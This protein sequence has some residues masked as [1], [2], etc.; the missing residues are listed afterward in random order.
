M[1]Q[2][3]PLLD[4]EEIRFR[5]EAIFP[6]GIPNRQYAVRDIAAKTIFVM[7]YI[8]A[9]EGRDMWLRPDQVT[10]MTNRQSSRSDDESRIEWAKKSIRPS[11]EPIKGRWYAQNTREP[12][13]DETLRQ[14]LLLLGAVT[15]RKG[16][17]TT[18]PEGRY[19]LQA[20]FA[21][22]FDPS[23]TGQGL[24]TAVDQWKTLHL[25][26][27]ALARVALVRKATVETGQGVIVRFPNDETRRLAEGPSSVI[28][29]AVVE[30]FAPR[31]LEKPGVLWLSES[32]VKESRRD[33]ELAKVLHLEIE[34]HK[35]LPDLILV[36]LGPTEP[37]FVFVEVVATD[38]AV[39]EMRREVL[40]KLVTD[41]G[42]KETQAGFVTAYLDREA[43]AFKRTFSALAWC[44]F[45][46]CLSEPDKI[47]GLHK[48][49]T[50]RRLS[51]LIKQP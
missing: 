22:L 44:S 10:K 43:P 32:A 16:L 19:A 45:A 46:W 12:I 33:I 31:F 35:N 38:G 28:A 47:I 39:T 29:K 34:A 6:E 23:L 9:I 13:R 15:E 40:L 7:M 21:N 1:S 42:Y 37:L 24:Q 20:A 41:A 27:S 17:S 25:S 5:L 4:W 49:D 14:G 3:P 11:R 18:S 48:V 26:P 2:L 30:D 36:D 51:D 50:G 8:G